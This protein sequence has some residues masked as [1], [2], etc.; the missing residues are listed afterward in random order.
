MVKKI[1][2][3]RQVTKGRS[4]TIWRAQ[5]ISFPS[6]FDKFVYAEVTAAET[7]PEFDCRRN[8][9]HSSI[10]FV[11]RL[12]IDVFGGVEVAPFL[13]IVN[14]GY[15]IAGR[16]TGDTLVKGG[17]TGI[18]LKDIVRVQVNQSQRH[19]FECRYVEVAGRGGASTNV[20]CVGDDKCPTCHVAEIVCVGCGQVNNPC[21]RC[22]AQTVGEGE[23]LFQ[24]DWGAGPWIVERAQWDGSDI[25]HVS[26]AGGGLF[27][28]ERARAIL[29]ANAPEFFEF[30]P[31]ILRDA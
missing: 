9:S 18:R 30:S 12:E 25:F 2:F 7:T 4:G 15:V 22:G 26:G 19:T 11:H 16:K 29:T 14:G 1:V 20:R 28:T 24:I 27:V 6:S 23:G 13:P 10:D 3:D 31:A 5:F 8:A 21:D 17:L